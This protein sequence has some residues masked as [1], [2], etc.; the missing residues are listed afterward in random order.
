MALTLVDNVEAVRFTFSTTLTRL[1][2]TPI[3]IRKGKDIKRLTV[4]GRWNLFILITRLAVQ[5]IG[6]TGRRRQRGPHNRRLF[7]FTSILT[8]FPVEGAVS[9]ADMSRGALQSKR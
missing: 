7:L 1:L 5:Q 3:L 2:R 9:G 4:C 8:F 6:V